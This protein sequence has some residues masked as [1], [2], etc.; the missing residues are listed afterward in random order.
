MITK[1]KNIAL[2]TGVVTTLLFIATLYSACRKQDNTVVSTACDGVVCKNGGTCIE[3]K[4]SCTPGYEGTYCDK[5]SY[6]RYI[7]NWSVTET[8]IG[9][10]KASNINAV[11]KY[12]LNIRRGE[13][14]L[15]LFFDNLS[16]SYSGVKG[17]LG[18]KYSGATL[19]GASALNFV[20][21]ANQSIPATYTTIV[22]SNGNI[23]E[24]GE[25]LSCIYYTSN[26]DNAVVVR[27]TI[28]LTGEYKP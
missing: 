3:G 14:I 20:I 4:C 19:Q 22:S 11:K 6:A 21:V 17:A 18:R 5:A 13:G 23:S 7:G 28:N 25:Y 27:D 24:T 8:I 1:L 16:N 2:L 10:S 9:S 26:Y 12:T 15:E